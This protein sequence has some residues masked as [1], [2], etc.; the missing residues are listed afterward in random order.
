MEHCSLAVVD[1][2]WLEPVFFFC[3]LSKLVEYCGLLS[4]MNCKFVIFDLSIELLSL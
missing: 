3:C 1:A 4:R 2:C